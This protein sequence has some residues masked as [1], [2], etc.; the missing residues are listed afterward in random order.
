ML[1]QTY[2]D[3]SW[4]E[5]NPPILGPLTHATWMASV[6]FDGARAFDGLTPDLDRHCQ[7]V[8][9]SAVSFGLEPKI[10]A[11]RIE[12]IALEGV[13][14]FPK[15]AALYIRPMFWSESGDK[16]FFV[17][18]DPASTRFCLTLHEVPMPSR[19]G[20]SVCLSSIRRPIPT[21]APTYAKASCLY[22]NSG[23][24]LREAADR[25]FDNAVVLDAMGNV[26]ELATANIWIAKDGK[27][28]T[29]VAN[30]CFLAGITRDRV[31]QLLRQ[32]GVDVVE[33]VITWD[34]VLAAD[35]VFTT[36]NLGKVMAISRVEER[37]LQPGPVFQ[38]AKEAYFTWAETT[39]RT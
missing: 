13:A 2:L 20:Y 1:P 36:G 31:A 33:R 35:E 8:I 18:P 3:G 4:L 21:M 27:A 39:R 32:A 38:T 5:G 37:D 14:R 23:R 10:G 24:A 34:E 25:G 28:L 30:G 12:E 19:D 22:P 9:D 11:A 29:P 6:V 7:R 15:G 26:A 17:M 16:R